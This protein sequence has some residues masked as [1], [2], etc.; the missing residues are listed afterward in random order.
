MPVNLV[1]NKF[2][3]F[4]KANPWMQFVLV[5]V[6]GVAVGALFY[7]TKKIEDK[8]HQQDQL[9]INQLTQEKQQI[10]TTLTQKIDEITQQKSDLELS[11]TKQIMTLQIQVQELENKKVETYYKIVHPDGTVEERK[12]SE[13]ESSSSSKVISDVQQDYEKKISD[14]NQQWQ[15][16]LDTTVQTQQAQ[17]D[18]IIQEKDKQISDLESSHSVTIN[19]KH[20]GIEGGYLTSKQYYLHT[21]ADLFGPIFIGAHVNTDLLSNTSVGAGVGIRF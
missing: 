13:S 18:T 8:V 4:V 7:P 1:W 17:F 9:V 19:E 14:I 2:V 5:F 12:Y 15:I 21:S 16:K 6:G 11:T 3:S 10:Q 20:F